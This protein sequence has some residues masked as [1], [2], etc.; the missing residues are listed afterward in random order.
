LLYLGISKYM[1]LS[2]KGAQTNLH[3]DFTGTSVFYALV[4]GKKKFVTFSP[5]PKNLALLRHWEQ[6]K[7]KDRKL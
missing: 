1:L 2:E 7:R 6:S 5:T 3:I 4:F